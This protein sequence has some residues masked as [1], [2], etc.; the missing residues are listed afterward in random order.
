MAYHDIIPCYAQPICEEIG[1][2]R[3][4]CKDLLHHLD[5]KTGK[6]LELD[7]LKETNARLM[8]IQACLSSIVVMLHYSEKRHR[9]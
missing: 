1:T 7:E 3:D 6:S 5:F 2:G 9:D 4:S 8:E